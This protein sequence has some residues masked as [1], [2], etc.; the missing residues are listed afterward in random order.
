MENN[1][2]LMAEDEESLG[3]LVVESLS[4]KGFVMTWAKDGKEALDLLLKNTYDLVILDVMMPKKDGFEVAKAF[5]EFNAQTPI[6]F[7]TSKSQANDVVQGFTIGGNDYLK[8]P[9]KIAELVIRM[10]NLLSQI[11][12]SQNKKQEQTIFALGQFKY[13]TV[14]QSLKFE[15]EDEVILTHRESELLHHLILQ[16]NEILNRSVILKKLWGND[17]FFS[18]RSMDVFITKLRKK[19]KKD[20]SL[21]IVN[22]RG[23]GYKLTDV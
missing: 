7:L 19:L 13:N 2:V 22:A 8:K 1:R 18:A 11:N 16:K 4:N 20:P 10:K 6:I 21:K 5:R 23:L 12:V 3:D 9:F 14:K 15:D 17:D